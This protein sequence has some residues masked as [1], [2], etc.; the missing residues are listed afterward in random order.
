MINRVQKILYK[1]GCVSPV[2]I[3]L[4]ISLWIQDT[5]WQWCM[6]LILG[7][8]FGCVYAVKFIKL[9]KQKLSSLEIEIQSIEQSDNEV[10]AYIC[11]YL[12]PIVG[13]IWKDDTLMWILMAVY[14]FIFY[15]KIE[16]MEI[17]P[18]L[19]LANYHFYKISL[20][21]G[22]ENC[23]F[24]SKRKGIRSTSEIRNVVRVGENLLVDE[25]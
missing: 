13:V 17:C 16:T 10:I 9:C 6:V 1:Q 3:T 19:L 21:T 14:V 11:S 22:I 20:S 5:D 2:L 7:G 23:I 18:V 12:I 8:V 25:E 15:I 24:I 4:G